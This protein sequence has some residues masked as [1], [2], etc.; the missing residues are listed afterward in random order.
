MPKPSESAGR[1]LRN[2]INEAEA[3]L[4]NLRLLREYERVEG[5]FGVGAVNLLEA[6]TRGQANAPKG[7]RLQ[8]AIEAVEAQL[9][10][11]HRN[12]DEWNAL[13]AEWEAEQPG[14]DDAE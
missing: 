4:A 11:L 7:A 9:S 2:Q 12:N 10:V 13:Q 8:G 1:V 5:S 14:A 6:L 3:N